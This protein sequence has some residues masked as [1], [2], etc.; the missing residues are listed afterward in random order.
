MTATIY[1]RVSSEGDRQSTERQVKELAAYA[2]SAN[3]H[4]ARIFEE[5]A[6]GTKD[7]RHVLADCVDWCC[8]GN[9]GTL[10][11]SEISR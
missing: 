3:F 11:V 1:A 6:S 2:K 5:K 10:L 9:A 7:D 4:V 8:A